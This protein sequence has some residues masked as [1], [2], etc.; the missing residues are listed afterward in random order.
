MEAT[1]PCF[2]FKTGPLVGTWASVLCLGWPDSKPQRFDCLY[3][4]SS[5]ITGIWHQTWLLFFNVHSVDQTQVLISFDRL[6]RLPSTASG[7]WDRVT[8]NN[9][10][11]LWTRDLPA[12]GCSSYYTMPPLQ[13]LI[14]FLLCVFTWFLL[15]YLCVCLSVHASELEGDLRSLGAGVT[16]GFEDLMQVLGTELWSPGR[17]ASALNY[18]AISP[19]LDTSNS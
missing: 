7:F 15:M 14:S 8:R 5:G 1:G 2:F 13:C 16:G 19:A 6:P 4:F 18:W 9:P 17:A 12:S 11:W 3:L 10:G